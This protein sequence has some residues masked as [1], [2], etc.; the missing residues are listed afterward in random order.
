MF[1]VAGHGIWFGGLGPVP[2]HHAPAV[3]GYPVRLAGLAWVAGRAAS[4][5]CRAEPAV[6]A[7]P[8]AARD[9]CVDYGAGWDRR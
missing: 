3:C 2:A 4:A 1:E 6:L 9:H 5:G 7:F 8:S